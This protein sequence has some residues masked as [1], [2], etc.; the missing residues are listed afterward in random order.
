MRLRSECIRID[1]MNDK[2]KWGRSINGRYDTKSRR[3][4]RR[5]KNKIVRDDTKR[6]KIGQGEQNEVATRRAQKLDKTGFTL[7]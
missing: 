4:G 2:Q 3:K 5:M 1:I 6:K 7:I